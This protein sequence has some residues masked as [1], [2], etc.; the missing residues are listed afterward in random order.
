MGNT[1]R[2]DPPNGISVGFCIAYPRN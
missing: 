2:L 1:Y